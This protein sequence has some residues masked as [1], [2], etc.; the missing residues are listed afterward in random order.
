MFLS[1]LHYTLEK[2][3]LEIYSNNTLASLI[4]IDLCKI[5]KYK[6]GMESTGCHS[7]IKRKESEN[8]SEQCNAGYMPEN[9]Y[10]FFNP[11]KDIGILFI[12][13]FFIFLCKSLYMHVILSNFN[14]FLTKL[15]TNC[16]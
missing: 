11:S 3:F 13:L 14:F 12:F 8:I 9:S 4:V 5:V 10:A 7:F 1:H 2:V 15:E 6:T 16:G